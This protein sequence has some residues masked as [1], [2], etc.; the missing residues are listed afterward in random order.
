MATFDPI[1]FLALEITQEKKSN[2][3]GIL[4]KEC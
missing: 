1:V 2:F 3:G 4:F